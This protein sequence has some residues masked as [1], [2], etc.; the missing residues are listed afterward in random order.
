M[1]NVLVL[2]S[3][4]LINLPKHNNITKNQI[5]LKT[6]MNNNPQLCE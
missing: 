2:S 5:Y 4:R 6:G 1:K 3:D